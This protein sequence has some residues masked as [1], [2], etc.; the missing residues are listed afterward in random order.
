MEKNK[1][2]HLGLIL[3][4]LAITF[5]NILPTV[6]YYIQPLSRSIGL[7]D[8][9][10]IENQIASRNLE[11]NKEIEDWIRSYSKEIKCNIVSLS[12]D[13]VNHDFLKVSFKT[14]SEADTFKNLFYK[15]VVSIPQH[16][17]QLAIVDVDLEDSKVVLVSKK[18][19]IAKNLKDFFTFTPTFEKN[20][21][22]PAYKQIQQENLY[23][24][25]EKIAFSQDAQL[26]KHVL[27]NKESDKKFEY[28][29]PLAEKISK[30]SLTLANNP[31]ALKRCLSHFTQG[32]FENK[33]QVIKQTTEC[34]EQLRERVKFEKIKLVDEEKALQKESKELPIAK[35]E[36]LTY[37]EN[38][39]EQLFKAISLTKKN[40]QLLSAGKKTA[41]ETTIQSIVA[42]LVQA[43]P[44]ETTKVSLQGINPVIES[45]SYNASLGQFILHPYADLK[46]TKASNDFS[47]TDQIIMDEIARI[48]FA[49]NHSIDP[50]LG[51]F[52]INFHTV[53]S[54][55]SI[56]NIDLKKLAYS[57]LDDLKAVLKTYYKPESFSLGENGVDLTYVTGFS[58]P[59]LNPNSLYVV[60]K[61][62]YKTISKEKNE[63]QTDANLNFYHDIG[64]LQSI[65]QP[66][67]FQL[68]RVESEGEL[69]DSSSDLVF[70]AR[71]FF[72]SLL[73]ATQE[74]F[75]VLPNKEFASLQFS[76][77]KQRIFTL[78]KIETAAHNALIKWKN[79]YFSAI[80]HPY[81]E[82]QP[83]VPKPTKSTL[84]SNF[85]LNAKKYF[86]G[87]ER[88]VLKWGLDLSGGKNVEIAL[89]DHEGNKVTEEK[90][91]KIA[92]NEL[93]S[94]VNKLGVSE[95]SIRAE[96]DHVTLDFPGSQELSARDLIQSSSMT[97]NVVNEK[98]TQS[99]PFLSEH[100]SRF[101]QD[102]W[103]QSLILENQ[104]PETLQT[105]AK[106]LLY[107]DGKT[108]ANA[109]PRTDSAK[110][111]LENGLCLE[112]PAQ[113]EGLNFS[114]SK[115]VPYRVDSTL[116]HSKFSN[117]LMIVFGESALEGAHLTNIH[118]GFDSQ[119]GNFLSF[120]VKKQASSRNG[121]ITNP[122]ST[123]AAWTEKF[124]KDAIKGSP[125]EAFTRGS[126]Y[127]MAVVLNGQ[128]ISSPTLNAA[129]K[130]SGRISGQ[131]SQA[132]VQKLEADLKAGSLTFTPKIL[133]EKNVSPELGDQERFYGIVATLVALAAVV[134]T[135]T[136]YY[137]FAGFIASVA[138]IFNLLI[139]WAILQN[140]EATLTLAGL[141][142]VVLT[143]GMAVDANVLVFERIKE[144]LKIHQKL[145]IA[146]E[147]GYE[148]AF[149]A[150]IDSNLTTIL[151]ALVLLNFD[152]GPVKGFAVTLIIGVASSMFTALFMTRYFFRSWIAKNPNKTLNMNSWIKAQNIQF[153]KY[154][155]PAFLASGLIVLLGLYFGIQQKQ[156]LFGMD[157]TGGYATTMTFKAKAG[158]DYK[159]AIEKTLVDAG[160]S[161]KDFSIRE[162]SSNHTLR[163]FLSKSTENKLE[164]LGSSNQSTNIDPKITAL[165]A[166]VQANNLP[167]SE[168][169]SL[170]MEKSWTQVSGQMSETMRNQA[171]IGIAIALIGI[172][173]YITIR[174]EMK[175]ALAST[176]GLGFVIV[177]TLSLVSI[178]NHL[179]VPL[180]IDLN[181]VAAVLTI[182]GYSL[183]DTIIVFDRIREDLKLNPH[184]SIRQIANQSLNTTLSRTLLTS[185]TTMIVLVALVLL[186]GSSIF[187][188][189][190]VMAL[191]VFIGTLSTFYCATPL[192]LYFEKTDKKEKKILSTL[193]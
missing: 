161:K 128:V 188:F 75:T 73:E 37:L 18:L 33:S 88:K 193:A 17:K 28:L 162:L 24:I 110:I 102:V 120:E 23:S 153:I 84:I 151:A 157:F 81:R 12:Q 97:F 129:I 187:S 71:T 141:A 30:I 182:V 5:Y 26:V 184:L 158:E 174:F 124:S 95:V 62:G 50:S 94:R 64:K 133:S 32:E 89:F 163:I 127:R 63:E 176:L 42:S 78:N 99:N 178:L 148:K 164:F 74:N 171:L 48:S 87:D 189:S 69:I 111:L 149:T 35:R 152:S 186:G 22:S 47:E 49:I 82:Q 130:E 101:L 167:L 58:S 8:Q 160:F 86:R 85:I 80:N 115:I 136:V 134:F 13:D 98:F 103:N 14:E 38:K 100:V 132:E 172:L 144:E 91:L 146:I 155:K 93:Y 40:S 21:L 51:D 72:S 27:A 83:I 39:E 170:E 10:S 109:K 96:G 126:G 123:L 105:I 92:I 135:M 131:F 192:L 15:A 54:P 9:N 122:Q 1:R 90:D 119:E 2:W 168:K 183:N 45:V 118:S 156:T 138:V 52:I 16:S 125:F 150:I 154:A 41:P 68:S 191:G 56:L 19:G 143:V 46:T 61:N 34:L 59:S 29:H 142:G 140:I 116:K 6:F 165:Y 3:T 169:A 20:Q 11:F 190:F 31:T 175:F 108:H 55:K 106:D 112:K 139:M 53:D 113:T 117:P 107:G 4:V 44:N 79:D 7:Q 77:L 76:D 121:V 25:L 65:L 145:K 43:N 185:G 104:D 57:C 173:L 181:M 179:G 66:L 70:E 137:R 159:S 180:Q 177:T 60:L 67:G 147:S 36:Q 166:L 114:Y